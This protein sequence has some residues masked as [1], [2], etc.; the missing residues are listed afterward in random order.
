MGAGWDEEV[1]AVSG[2]DAGGPHESLPWWGGRTGA[3]AVHGLP[4]V[5]EVG[6]RRHV[7]EKVQAGGGGPGPFVQLMV[8]AEGVPVFHRIEVGPQR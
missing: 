6:A 8:G 5:L 4:Q 7:D 1:L 3:G 2:A